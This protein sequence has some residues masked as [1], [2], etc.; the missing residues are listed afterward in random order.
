M[1]FN[2]KVQI[3]CEM[4]KNKNKK[5][6]F[7]SS[8]ICSLR[9]YLNITV[10]I[11]KDLVYKLCFTVNSKDM[12]N[13]LEARTLNGCHLEYLNIKRYYLLSLSIC[14]AMTETK[15]IVITKQ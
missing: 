4:N 9:D 5:I 3:N 14:T 10:T 15:D 2:D 1:F 13:L 7:C 8:G 11:N 12:H 6:R